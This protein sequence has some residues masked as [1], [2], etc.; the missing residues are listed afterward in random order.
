MSFNTSLRSILILAALLV[1]ASS[2]SAQAD[3]GP[4]K[5][6]TSSSSQL[7][8]TANAQTALQLDISTASGGATVTGATGNSSTGVFSLD[9][10][11]VNGLGLGTPS[12]GVSVNVQAGGAV[13]TSP[14]SLTPRYSGFSTSSASVSVLL[15]GTAG[16]AA[17][18]SATREGAAAGTVVAPSTTVPNIFTSSA[19]NGTAITRYVGVFVSNANGASSVRGSLTARLIYRVYVQ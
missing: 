11:D 13:Y 9:F 17:G 16:N 3:L 14:I 12:T 6:A 10:G 8:L 5:N 15:D 1:F 7:N 18:R 2:V 19:S 4:Q